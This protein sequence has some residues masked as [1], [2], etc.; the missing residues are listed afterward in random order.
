MKTNLKASSI[1]FYV[2]QTALILST[3]LYLPSVYAQNELK[4]LVWDQ[5]YLPLEQRKKF[6]DFIA[7]KYDYKVKI[8]PK[9]IKGPDHVFHAIRRGEVDLAAPTHNL[10]NDPRFS[11]IKNQ[12]I[13][14]ID[15]KK[16]RNFDAVI[17]VFRHYFRHQDG[18]YYGIPFIFGPYGLIYN[19]Q[20]VS[21][22]PKHWEILWDPEYKNNYAVSHEH[23]EANA[24]ITALS[25]GYRE[26][27]LSDF[28][29]LSKDPEFVNR[30]A[31]LAVNAGAFWKTDNAESMLGK[32]ISM[33]WGFAL[34]L[35]NSKEKSWEFAFVE[36]GTTAWMDPYVI[37]HTLRNKPMLRKVAEEWVNYSLSKDYQ[38][39]AVVRKL[40]S[41]PVNSN[42]KS[43][44]T[45]EEV[46]QFH[47]DEPDFVKDHLILWPVLSIRARNGFKELWNH[48]L[49]NT[50]GIPIV[51]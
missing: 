19:T 26:K 49:K 23:Y 4:I 28:E 1:V 41:F 36:E 44:L 12:L 6:E 30:L 20:R 27:D 33:S 24:Y 42:I 15:V 43:L 34:P 14:P 2:L 46:A 10:I 13:L 37:S 32:P 11:L 5:A 50:Q 39:N 21:A 31:S 48:S 29:K 38:T 18:N 7:R 9:I 8:V 45:K 35:L 22:T 16:I 51:K 3:I 40:N 47:L 17:E 25:L